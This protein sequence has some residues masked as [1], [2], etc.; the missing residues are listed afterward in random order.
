MKSTGRLDSL[1]RLDDL[2]PEYRDALTHRNLVANMQQ[3][4]AWI[5]TL[6]ETLPVSEQHEHLFRQM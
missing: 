1:G 4:S 5:V 6:P 3:A 2:T